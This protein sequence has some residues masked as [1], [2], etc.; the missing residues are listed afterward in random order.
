MK[1]ETKLNYNDR[2]KTLPTAACIGDLFFFYSNVD[3]TESVCYHV[4]EIFNL[5][6]Y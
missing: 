1:A 3:I 4:F 5:D 6:N 2:N